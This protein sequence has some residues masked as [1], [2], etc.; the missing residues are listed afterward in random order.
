MTV[1]MPADYASARKLIAESYA[2]NGPV[3]LRFTRDAVPCIY[4]EEETFEI[5]RAKRLREGRDLTVFANG[6]TLSIALK[7]A[8]VL[9]EEGI[10]AAV[11]DMHTIKPLDQAAVLQAIHGSGRIITV[12]DHNIINGLGSAVCEVAAETGKG[13]VVRIGVQDRFGESAPYEELLKLNGITVENI[14]EKAREL[15]RG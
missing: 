11:Y 15:M 6:D 3:Y 9:E 5:G 2:Y 4:D 1:I 8:E 10:A 12:E 13:R 7:A 14:C